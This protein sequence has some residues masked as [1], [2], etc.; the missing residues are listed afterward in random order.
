MGNFCLW[1]QD[2]LKL[3]LSSE[4]FEETK[5]IKKRVDLSKIILLQATW[6]GYSARKKIS[7]VPSRSK[8]E[9]E[10]ENSENSTE[11]SIK[12]TKSQLKKYKGDLV[13]RARQ[14]Q[15]M[16]IWEDGSKYDGTWEDNIPNGHGTY[17]DLYGD[18][19]TGLFLQGRANGFGTLTKKEG[20]VY[21][22]NW[23]LD[24][25]KGKGLKYIQGGNVYIGDFDHGRKSGY[26]EL[27]YI[28]GDKYKGFFKNGQFHGFGVFLWKTG[29][30]Y[31][32]NWENGK[33]AGFGL[34]TY[35]NQRKYTG[36]F[37]YNKRHGFG[38]VTLPDGTEK[39]GIWEKGRYKNIPNILYTN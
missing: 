18:I 7:L 28:N 37:E 22:G 9:D 8:L 29:K 25:P 24:S 27:T 38:V 19:Y 4:D 14:G 12:I 39:Q 15:G 35:P 11:M 36:F 10:G 30:S 17:C 34:F 26:G 1:Y 33:R 16:Q 3:D 31:S 6:R 21:S 5:S 23:V 2:D 13:G 32:G 20:G